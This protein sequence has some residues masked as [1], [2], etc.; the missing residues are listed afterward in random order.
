MKINFFKTASMLLVAGCF[1]L[2]LNLSSCSDAVDGNLLCESKITI[3]PNLEDVIYFDQCEPQEY[4]YFVLV[5]GIGYDLSSKGIEVSV[6]GDI[7][8]VSVVNGNSIHIQPTSVG[9]GTITVTATSDCR[10]FEHEGDRFVIGTKTITILPSKL[11]LT[12]TVC[13][14][15]SGFGKGTLTVIDLIPGQEYYQ[16]TVS[17]A[18]IADLLPQ[19]DSPKCEVQNAKGDFTITVQKIGS[20]CLFD[21]VSFPVILSDCPPNP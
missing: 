13:K 15:V 14:D 17:P 21:P 12:Y 5:D 4:Y 16:W 11:D 6:S 1:L 10:Y 7:S 19:A 18:G 8:L 2:L 9:S 20:K 3:E